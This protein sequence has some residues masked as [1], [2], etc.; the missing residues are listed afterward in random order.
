MR[1]SRRYGENPDR[2]LDVPMPGPVDPFSYGAAI[3]FLFL[4]EHCGAGKVRALLER[5][6]N[7]AEGIDDPVW[8]QVLEPMLQ[9]EASVSFA[10]AFAQFATYNLFTDELADPTRSYANGADCPPV[11]IE[12]VAAPYVDDAM[13]VFYASSQY[14]GLDPAGRSEMTAALVVPEG[15]EDD[16]LGLVMLLGVERDSAYEPVEPVTD[17]TSGTQSV[18][19]SGASRFVTLVVNTLLQGD[20]RRLSAQGR[21]RSV[22][23]VDTTTIVLIAFGLSMDAF[24]VAVTYGLSFERREH[25]RALAVGLA[26][27]LLGVSL[28][29]PAAT[30]GAITFVPPGRQVT[31]AVTGA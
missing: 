7:G 19:T 24:A 2:S 1:H 17:P 21:A 25:R 30:I 8:L 23:P 22:L 28:W 5:C 15:G 13:R 4:E 3:F 18:D 26:L 14:Y 27:S 11:K 16:L 31:G 20:S 9:A 6:E 12:Q 29:R 10:D